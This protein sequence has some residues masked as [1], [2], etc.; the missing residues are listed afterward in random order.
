MWPGVSN[1][2]RFIMFYFL[3]SFLFFFFFFFFNHFISLSL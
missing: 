2:T 1:Q 3:L